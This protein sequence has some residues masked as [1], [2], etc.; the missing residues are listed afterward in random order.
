MMS[1]DF[2]GVLGTTAMTARQM[3]R[4]GRSAIIELESSEVDEVNSQATA[5]R[6]PRAA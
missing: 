5:S 2:W 6:S 1:L 3:L 4:L